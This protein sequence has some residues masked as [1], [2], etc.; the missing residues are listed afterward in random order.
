SVH[1]AAH[2][3]SS[4]SPALFLGVRSA[5]ARWGHDAVFDGHADLVRLHAWLPLQLVQDVSLDVL[6]GLRSDSCHC[7]DAHGSSP[8]CDKCLF[9]ELHATITQRAPAA[10]LI[11]AGRAVSA[12]ATGGEHAEP[13]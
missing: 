4:L 13:A 5:P 11:G 6:V 8:F 7:G 12:F 10:T 9:D 2:P 3:V 1:A